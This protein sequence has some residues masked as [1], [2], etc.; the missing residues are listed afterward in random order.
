MDRDLR[1]HLRDFHEVPES[2]V[3]D[4]LMERDALQG[5]QF[6]LGGMD[7]PF[8]EPETPDPFQTYQ[9]PI[10][11]NDDQDMKPIDPRLISMDNPFDLHKMSLLDAEEAELDKE[12]GLDELKTWNAQNGLPYGA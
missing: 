3:D 8:F 4:M 6:W 1:R 5:G 7:E 2:E 12:M 11:P 10:I 9:G